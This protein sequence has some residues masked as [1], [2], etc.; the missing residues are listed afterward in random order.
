MKHL[1]LTTIAAVLLVGCGESQPPEPTTVKTPDISIHEADLAAGADVNTK[2]GEETP[3]HLAAYYGDDKTAALLIA[4][5]ADV[6]AKGETEET[7]L[8]SAALSHAATFGQKEVAELLIAKGADVNA[9]EVEGAT[10]LHL[11]PYGKGLKAIAEILIANGADVNIKDDL[12]DTPLD[13]AVSKGEK[14]IADLLRKHGGKSG[15]KDSIHTAAGIGNIEAVKQHLASGADVNAKTDVWRHTPLHRAA[16]FG[17]K[18]IVELL[19]A[20]GADVNAKREEEWTPLHYAACFGHKEIA[21][22]LIA[23]GADVNAKSDFGTPLDS[24]IRRKRTE[25][26]NLLRKHDGMTGEEL[27]AIEALKQHLAAGADVNAKD[28]GG[29]TPLHTAALHGYNELAELLIAAGADVNAKDNSG[30]TPLH[31]A[32]AA[33]GWA[34]GHKEVAELLIANGADVN[35]KSND[36]WTPL[37][38]AIERG[39]TEIT[40]LLRKHGGKTI[41]EL[42]IHSSA[43]RGN[44][45]AVKQHLAAGTD[46][47]AKNDTGMTPLHEATR[48]GHKEIVEL[49]IAKSANVNAKNGSGET[50]LDWA[51]VEIA[52][53][54]RKHGGKTKRELKAAGK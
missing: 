39:H 26:A 3:L 5:G 42:S 14:E 53:L 46:V 50:P 33:R 43:T 54:L 41:V 32:A 47:N 23:K 52:E 12:G 9:K 31:E 16:C 7:P 21:E 11:V 48:N 2:I 37:D 13:A 51:K 27:K 38:V 17:H 35:G 6:N 18:E 24:G 8:H 44:I 49:L 25:V 15:V 10:P 20:E 28:D 19:I 29:V 36:G 45:E 4:K 34:G 1:L 40:E 30:Y 22:L